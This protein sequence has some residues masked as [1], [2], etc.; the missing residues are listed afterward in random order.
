MAWAKIPV[1]IRIFN[2]LLMLEST[3]IRLVDVI[4]LLPATGVKVKV[5]K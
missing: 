2:G 5:A 4:D 3:T 1:V